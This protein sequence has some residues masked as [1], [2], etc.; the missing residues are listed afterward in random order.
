MTC[1]FDTRRNR[2][3]CTWGEPVQV[4]VN[5][6]TGVI[7]RKKSISMLLNKNGTPSSKDVKR[8]EDHHML[9]HIDRFREE[10]KKMNYFDSRKGHVCAECGNSENV[11]PYFLPDSQEIRWLCRDHKL[12]P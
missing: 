3:V 11:Q 10:L 6:R 9:Q 2:I 4:T 12:V 8:H 7:N 1:F 5:K